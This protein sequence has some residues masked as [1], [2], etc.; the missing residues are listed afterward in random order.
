VGVAIRGVVKDRKL[1]L[2]PVPFG[3]VRITFQRAGKI[4]D[5]VAGDEGQRRDFFSGGF[6]GG[7]GIT[8]NKVLFANEKFFVRKHVQGLRQKFGPERPTQINGFLFTLQKLQNFDEQG[9]FSKPAG[10]RPHLRRTGSERLEF[11]KIEQG[12]NQR[13]DGERGRTVGQT[14]IRLPLV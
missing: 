11:R 3:V 10:L 14:N 2:F 4:E 1:D 9:Y 7:R 8:Q 6:C 5:P 13:M 12:S